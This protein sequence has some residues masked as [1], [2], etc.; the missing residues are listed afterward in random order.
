MRLKADQVNA[1]A[2]WAEQD[3]PGGTTAWGPRFDAAM[4]VAQAIRRWR[5]NPTPPRI[6]IELISEAAATEFDT[7]VSGIRSSRREQS[8]S[9]PRHVVWY[10]AKE[11]AGDRVCDIARFFGRDHSTVIYGLRK[12]DAA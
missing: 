12:L 3:R 9:V 11:L 4:A 7:T 1:L 6:N 2:N 10:L 8:L 5:L